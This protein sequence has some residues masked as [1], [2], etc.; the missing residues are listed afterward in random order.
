MVSLPLV[1][2]FTSSVMTWLYIWWLSKRISCRWITSIAFLRL[3]ICILD[4]SKCI[5]LPP[6]VMM[7]WK[8]FMSIR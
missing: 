2:E 4:I 7:N 1:K 5:S 8:Y 3:F 6:D